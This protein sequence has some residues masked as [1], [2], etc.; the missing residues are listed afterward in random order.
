MRVSTRTPSPQQDTVCWMVDVGLYHCRIHA[1]SPSRGYALV[2]GDSHH[3]LVNPFEHQWP[4]CHAPAP[5]RLGV[6]HLGC[7]HAGE[8]PVHEVSAHFALQRGITPVADV[9]EDQQPQ[10]HFGRCSQPTAAAALGMPL[11]QGVVYRRHDLFICQHL[12]GVL[13]PV[14]AKIAHFVSDQTIAEIELDPPHLNHTV[15][16]S[17][18][19]AA[20]DAVAHD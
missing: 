5:H 16:L 8:V 11:R 20:P 13:H 17:A 2:P 14:F 1:H 3:P 19:D 10:H 7:A 9:L 6:G 4:E 15:P 18:F 12:I